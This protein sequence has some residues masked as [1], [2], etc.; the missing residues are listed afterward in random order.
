M[1][2]LKRAS[3]WMHDT[4]DGDDAE[5]VSLTR[6]GSTTTGVAARVGSTPFE[7]DEGDGMAISVESI[8]WL[9]AASAYRIGGSAT[10]PAPGD[11]I[12][13]T[14]DAVVYV[15]EVLPIGGETCYRF[16]DRRRSRLRV[17]S[18]LKTTE[19]V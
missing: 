1:G 12:R 8:D 10:L 7:V 15:Y 13:R 18:K 16:S 2:L 4:L 14:L 19:A 17:H 6:G 9:L 3:E 5:T 11:L